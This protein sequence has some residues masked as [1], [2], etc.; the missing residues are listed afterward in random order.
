MSR[1]TQQRSCGLTLVRYVF[2]F[3][4]SFL[5]VHIVTT[6]IFFSF[7]EVNFELLFLQHKFKP[8]A[9][10]F[11]KTI[12]SIALNMLANKSNSSVQASL[13]ILKLIKVLKIEDAPRFQYRQTFK[14]LKNTTERPYLH[15]NKNSS[16]DVLYFEVIANLDSVRHY[17]YSSRNL[18]LGENCQCQC[19]PFS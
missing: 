16:R 5:I 17:I 15:F 12:P 4:A 8:P 18:I 9:P 3:V 19:H 1:R 7:G 10:V 6:C 2:L 14:E 13:P 11:V